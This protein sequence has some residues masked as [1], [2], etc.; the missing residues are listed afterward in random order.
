[1]LGTIDKQVSS[2]KIVDECKIFYGMIV[3]GVHSH[4]ASVKIAY[5]SHPEGLILTTDAIQAMGLQQGKYTLG[6]MVVEIKGNRA[7]IDGT[8]TL[9]GR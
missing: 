2:E 3:D 7:Y 5:N 4:P 6:S 8:D 9:A 1:M